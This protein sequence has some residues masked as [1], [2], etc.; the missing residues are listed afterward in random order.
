MGSY[1][2]KCLELRT[3]KQPLRC[4]CVVWSGSYN[5]GS[6]DSRPSCSYYHLG[7]QGPFMIV[8]TLGTPSIHIEQS[9]EYFSICLPL[10]GTLQ[11]H[12]KA[13][14][15]KS[16]TI[17]HHIVPLDLKIPHL[18]LII[19]DPALGHTYQSSN[20]L[21]HAHDQAKLLTLVVVLNRAFHHVAFQIQVTASRA[22][23]AGLVPKPVAIIAIPNPLL[24]LPSPDA[25]AQL[26][27]QLRPEV[28]PQ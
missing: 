14:L 23:C 19:L 27:G 8:V 20:S 3:S 12:I 2:L 10:L 25:A 5:P 16:S 13:S 6:D 11:E 26:L 4:R 24:L 21:V 9:T 1:L 22:V 15:L 17:G 28:V 18:S 7:G